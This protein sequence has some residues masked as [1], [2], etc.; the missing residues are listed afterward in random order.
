MRFQKNHKL[1][2]TSLDPLDPTALSI[3][4]KPGVR[5]KLRQIPDWQD[6]LRES[7]NL[8]ISEHEGG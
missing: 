3:K 8:L 5:E 7:I 4:V 2:F 1:G 6:K